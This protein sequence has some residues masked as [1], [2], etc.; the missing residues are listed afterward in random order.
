MEGEGDE[1]KSKQA[2][3]RDWTLKPPLIKSEDDVLFRIFYFFHR[4]LTGP[5]SWGLIRGKF[6]EGEPNSVWRKMY[7]NH[8]SDESFKTGEATTRSVIETNELQ[9]AYFQIKNM[10]YYSKPCELKYVWKSP[11]KS[12][13][14]YAF[15]K[16]S[17]LF[18]F[19]KYAYGKIRQSGALQR[20][21]R[22]WMTNAKSLNCNSNNSMEPITLNRIG[23]L[24]ALVIMG[25]LFGIAALIIEVYNG[26][27]ISDI[28]SKGER[29]GVKNYGIY[30][31]KRL[32]RGREGGHKIRKKS[33]HHVPKDQ[34]CS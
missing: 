34:R 15:P 5:K 16:A 33:K 13:Y 24:I 4:V 31:V 30:L 6:L 29:F 19:F 9:T 21:N 25:V 23:S 12:F 11:E 7:K 22:K 18:P 20:V 8:M 26:P 14:S 3:K 1:I 28:P 10:A 17:P 27:S 2:Y 32:Q